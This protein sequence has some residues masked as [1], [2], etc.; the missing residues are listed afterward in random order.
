MA[1]DASPHIDYACVLETLGW[2]PAHLVVAERFC[3]RLLGMTVRPPV[4]AGGM[5]LAMAFPRCASVHTCF[6]RYPLDI[7]FIDR[8]GDILRVCESVAPWRFLSCAGAFAT[9]ERAALI[10]TGSARTFGVVRSGASAAVRP[11]RAA[12][13]AYDAG[14]GRAREKIENAP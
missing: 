1:S 2:Q 14:P 7:A 11:V 9:L 6:M 12:Q 5:P 8:G 3:D 10:S 13:R 4:T